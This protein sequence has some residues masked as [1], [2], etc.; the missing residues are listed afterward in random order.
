MGKSIRAR[1]PVGVPR[2][3]RGGADHRDVLSL[4]RALPRICKWPGGVPRRLV[5]DGTALAPVPGR[6]SSDALGRLHPPAAVLGTFAGLIGRWP[7]GPDC[8]T[9]D[10]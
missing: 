8:G 2:L 7:G 10:M 5:G 4:P 9:I 1:R 3:F 6:G